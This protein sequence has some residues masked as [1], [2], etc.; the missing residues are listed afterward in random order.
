[1]VQADYNDLRLN[2][3][4]LISKL[5]LMNIFLGDFESIFKGEGI[6]FDS[7]K[8]F[9]PGDNPKDL[10]LSTIVQSG[11][12]DI[13]IRSEERQLKVYIFTDL[14]GSMG[15]FDY[16]FF[17]HKIDIKVI[18]TGLI[19]YS[20]CNSYTPL[21]L[22]AFST[23]IE[24]FFPAKM[25]LAYSDEIFD[26]MIK[27]D[28]Q[29]QKNSLDIEKAISFLTK[30]LLKHNMVFL[31]SDFKDNIFQGDFTSLIR[32]LIEKFDLIPVIIIDPLEKTE[33]IKDSIYIVV[34]NSEGRGN[35]EIPLTPKKLKEMQDISAMHLFNLKCNFNKLGIDFIILDSPC[36][37]DCYYK[38]LSFFEIRKRIKK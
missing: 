7:T 1:M 35:A 19:A 4:G 8:P 38:F 29:I 20:A 26:W 16:M 36:L 22:C 24:R 25:G 34:E 15:K 27:H 17:A 30:E 31:I 11:D 18:A 10:D 2:K 23:E 21:G 5:K 12:E 37:D 33:I 28:C 3:A 6:E 32:P 13:I 14:S 9:E